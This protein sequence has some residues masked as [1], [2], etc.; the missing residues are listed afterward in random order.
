MAAMTKVKT[1]FAAQ[2]QNKEQVPVDC[3]SCNSL[4]SDILCMQSSYRIILSKLAQ[5]G[6]STGKHE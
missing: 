5:D 1:G 6:I 4:L 2:E 3:S